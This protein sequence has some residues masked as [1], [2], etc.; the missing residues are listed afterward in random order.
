V[1]MG[2]RMKGLGIRIPH[3][4]D[5]ALD[6]M[7]ATADFTDSDGRPFNKNKHIREAIREYL[8]KHGE[9]KADA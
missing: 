9:L 4:L 1:N 7:A 3:E 6:R 8:L 2:F 5:K